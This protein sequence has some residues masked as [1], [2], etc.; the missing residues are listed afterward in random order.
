M[1]QLSYTPKHM[2]LFNK[3]DG[4]SEQPSNENRWITVFDT[5]YLDQPLQSR[6]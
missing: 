3:E 5:H 2:V 1:R 4:F 6:T